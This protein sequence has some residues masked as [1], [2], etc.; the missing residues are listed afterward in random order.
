MGDEACAVHVVCCFL[1]LTIFTML[2]AVCL[3]F[4]VCFRLS[5]AVCFTR[6]DVLKLFYLLF[7]IP[8]SSSSR[9][10]LQ[11]PT[12]CTVPESNLLQ[13][14]THSNIQVRVPVIFFLRFYRLWY[15]S[16][17]FARQQK[18]S[19]LINSRSSCDPPQFVRIGIRRSIL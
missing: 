2:S 11:V 19:S 10:T 16:G 14:A 8:S 4:H 3:P 9:Q 18:T 15:L 6:Y 17:T 12:T 13:P 5:F 1:L 7:F